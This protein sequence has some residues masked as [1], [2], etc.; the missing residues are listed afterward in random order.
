MNAVVALVQKFRIL[1]HDDGQ[2]LIEYGLLAALVAIIAIAAITTIGTTLNS[3]F[4]GTF[5]GAI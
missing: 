3:L 2:D 1:R 5:P 4:Y